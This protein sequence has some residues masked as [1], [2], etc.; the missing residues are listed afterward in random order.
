MK[1]QKYEPPFWAVLYGVRVYT[2]FAKQIWERALEKPEPHTRCYMMYA[3]LFVSPQRDRF[4]V[5]DKFYFYLG[6]GARGAG[7]NCAP[8]NLP[9]LWHLDIFSAIARSNTYGIVVY[10]T[11]KVI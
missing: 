5:M 11:I 6:G 2:M 4:S 10:P 7:V 9:V 3:F 1:S 8:P